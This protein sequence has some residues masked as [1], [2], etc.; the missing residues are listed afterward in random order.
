[1]NPDYERLRWGVV[2]NAGRLSPEPKQRW[3]HVC[4]ATGLGSTSAQQLCRDAGFDPDQIVG[5]DPGDEP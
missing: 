3:S 4:D 2:A 1:M 5:T